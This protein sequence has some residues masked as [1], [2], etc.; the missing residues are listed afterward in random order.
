MG[1]WNWNSEFKNAN[2]RIDPRSWLIW[3]GLRIRMESHGI[4]RIAIKWELPPFGGIKGF[5]GK[6]ALCRRLRQLEDARS[7][8][9]RRMQQLSTTTRDMR[10]RYFAMEIDRNSLTPP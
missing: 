3:D 7:E 6:G 9:H 8:V 5:K 10:V 4:E 1:S 2:N